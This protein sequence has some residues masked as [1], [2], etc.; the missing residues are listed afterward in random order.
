VVVTLTLYSIASPVEVAEVVYL[1]LDLCE[2]GH[3]VRPSL[4]EIQACRSE[5]PEDGVIHGTVRVM[6]LLALN[7][8]DVMVLIRGRFGWN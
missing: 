1:V 6:E 7:G 5:S 2:D 3:L 4:V 8:P